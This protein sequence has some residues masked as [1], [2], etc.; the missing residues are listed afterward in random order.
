MEDVLFEALFKMKSDY[1]EVFSDFELQI[2]KRKTESEDNGKGKRKY[3]L[4][5]WITGIVNNGSA[6]YKFQSLSGNIFI[7]KH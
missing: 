7:R 5:E 1:G 4:E 6:E 2:Q 3:F